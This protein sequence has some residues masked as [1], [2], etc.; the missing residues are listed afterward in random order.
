MNDDR[1]QPS[2]LHARMCVWLCFF[3]TCLCFTFLLFVSCPVFWCGA[4]RY[5][6]R[7]VNNFNSVPRHNT[8]THN[9][10]ISTI[11]HGKWRGVL[12]Q[13]HSCFCVCFLLCGVVLLSSSLWLSGHNGTR[14]IGTTQRIAANRIAL[15]PHIHTPALTHVR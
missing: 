1:Q 2:M 6:A 5:D 7:D 9:N 12:Y 8:H 3:L 11:P 14:S 4:L 15:H 13:L 10:K